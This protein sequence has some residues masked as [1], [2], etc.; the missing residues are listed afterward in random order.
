MSSSS[1]PK[2]PLVSRLGDDN[3]K[4][5]VK[6][7]SI[8][9]KAVRR[10]LK[11]RLTMVCITVL[12]FMA[13]MTLSAGLISSALGINPNETDPINRQQAFGWVHPETGTTHILG[14]DSVGR[15][16]FT[17]LLVAGRVSLGIGFFGAI[18]TLT[19]GVTFGIITGYYGGVV[20]DIFN[21]IITTLDSI[22][23][24]YLLIVISVV[25]TPSA[26]A[27]VIAISLTSW[28]GV[29]RIVRGQTFQIR[30]LDYVTSA[31]ALGASAW[32]IMFSHI[33]PNLISILVVV[34]MRSI[35][36][37]M[38][39]EAALS[40][41]NFGVQPPTPTWG[42]MLTGAQEFIVSPNG[43]YLLLPPGLCIW[44]TVLCLY[45]IGDGVRDAFDPTS[46][47]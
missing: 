40:F 13:I 19:I 1:S 2:A 28:T 25:L 8:Y 41:L 18:I 43:I 31:R 15:D 21:W 27:L 16:Q 17:R 44:V 29:T 22:P 47:K 45:V 14:T 23:G 39:A 33:A 37:L 12:A 3:I 34:L 5:Y 9:Q 26:E 10:V 36:G 42:N 30:S 38:L 46:N 4:T 32:R 6:S 35:G 20:D 11:D 7:Q 24:L